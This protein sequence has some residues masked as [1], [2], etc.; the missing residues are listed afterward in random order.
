MSTIHVLPPL[1]DATRYARAAGLLMDALAR[2]DDL[3][4]RAWHIRALSA[5]LDTLLCGLRADVEHLT[6][7]LDPDDE[8]RRS[9]EA[10]I[11]ALTAAVEELMVQAHRFVPG[12]SS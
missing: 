2:G 12:Q 1:G 6:T 11:A 5:S 7:M 4:P 9:Y 10:Q 3:G 8:T